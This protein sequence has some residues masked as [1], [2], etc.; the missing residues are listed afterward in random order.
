[1]ILDPFSFHQPLSKATV[2]SVRLDITQPW[3]A[4]EKVVVRLGSIF[5]LC[6]LWISVVES[7]PKKHS[8]Q[9]RRDRTENHKDD[10]PGSSKLFSAAC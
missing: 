4:A 8:P 7:A 10:L 3:Q 5:C 6:D 9:R 1:M 2:R